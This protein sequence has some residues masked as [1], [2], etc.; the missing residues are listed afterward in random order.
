MHNEC[1]VHAK[2]IKLRSLYISAY[3]SSYNKKK[4]VATNQRPQI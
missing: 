2:H 3:Q 1:F 4:E